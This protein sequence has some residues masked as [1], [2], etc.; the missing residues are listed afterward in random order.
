MNKLGVTSILMVLSSVVVFFILRGPNANLTLAIGI[1]TTLSVI[2][3]LLAIASKQLVSGII[4]VL[5]NSAVLV[6]SFFL[7]LAKGIGG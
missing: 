2:G 4:G 7:L 1:L 3:I 5:L 6:F